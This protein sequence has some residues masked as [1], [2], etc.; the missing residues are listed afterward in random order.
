MLKHAH[1]FGL[2]NSIGFIY[3]LFGCGAIASL[4]SFAGY[5]FITSYPALEIVEPIAPTVAMAVVSSLIA[6]T[7][8][9]IFSFSSDAI[10]QSFLLDEEM[11]MAGRDRP[12]YLQEFADD[13]KNRGKGCCEGSCF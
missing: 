12:E 2:G 3:M 7:F 4:S 6:Y 9:S 10:F 1:R 13:L 8:L 11:R 5:I